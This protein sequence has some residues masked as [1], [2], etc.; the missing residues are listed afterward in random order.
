MSVLAKLLALV[1]ALLLPLALAGAWA[2]PVVTD[3]DRYVAAVAPLAEDPDVQ[4]AVAER[5]A[6]VVRDRVGPVSPAGGGAAVVEDATRRVVAGEA[7]ARAWRRA[8]AEVHR[9]FLAAMRSGDDDTLTLR[10]DPLVE[11]VLGGLAQELGLPR[12][13]AVT[14][15]L[16]VPVASA[17]DTARA[18]EAYRL[19]G[20]LSPALTLVWA[21]VLVLAL[22][23]G[24]RRSTLA[25]A[26]GTSALT[27]LALWAAVG[28]GG[29]AAAEAADRRAF[30]LGGEVAR[31]LYGGLTDGLRAWMLLAAG[32][33]AVVL[34]LTLLVRGGGRAHDRSRRLTRGIAGRPTVG[35]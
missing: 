14:T 17:A 13:P 10:L 31:V 15:T 23:P 35:P 22:L 20:A 29:G 34:A 24:R 18:R 19:V 26:A 4:E 25:V 21:A 33:S 16:A 30:P 32:V 7:F 28:L 12:R 6:Q 2:E 8:H 11:Q 9:Q 27:T 5:V 1:S 3:T